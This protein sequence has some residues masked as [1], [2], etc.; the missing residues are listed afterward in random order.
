MCRPIFCSRI[1]FD[2]LSLFPAKM[3]LGLWLCQEPILHSDHRWLCGVL[4][5]FRNTPCCFLLWKC[6]QIWGSGSRLG[7]GLPSH[8]EPHLPFCSL[9]NIWSPNCRS[10]I[11]SNVVP[12]KNM[13]GPALIAGDWFFRAAK[14]IFLSVYCWI[15]EVLVFVTG[16]SLMPF[17]V[18]MCSGRWSSS[19]LGS[20]TRKDQNLLFCSPQNIWSTT[21]SSRIRT[22]VTPCK[23]LL[24]PAALAGARAFYHATSHIFQSVHWTI[25]GVVLID[26]EYILILFLAEMCSGLLPSLGLGPSIRFP[27]WYVEPYLSFSNT[28]HCWFF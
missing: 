12:C 2:S 26:L 4:L 20:S 28:V 7:S 27:A 17:A 19:G 10:R 9:Q 6:A 8:Q 1:E 21:S 14:H 3:C 13:L 23:N 5:Q 25:C 18:Q 15:R 16:Y 22:D 11:N 24:R